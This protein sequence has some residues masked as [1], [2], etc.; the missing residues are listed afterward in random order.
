MKLNSIYRVFCK[1]IVRQL[2]PKVQEDARK[3]GLD[4]KVV[5]LDANRQETRVDCNIRN[6]EVI[7]V[8]PGFMPQVIN[9]GLPAVEGT[10]A[11]AIDIHKEGKLEIKVFKPQHSFLFFRNGMVSNLWNHLF[12]MFYLGAEKKDE[13]NGEKRWH[14]VYKPIFQ[15]PVPSYIMSDSQMREYLRDKLK[16]KVL[17]GHLKLLDELTL[18]PAK[19][20]KK[21][22][23]H[24]DKAPN[25]GV[26]ISGKS[27]DGL[28]GVVRAQ[29]EPGDELGEI[30]DN[31]SNRKDEKSGEGRKVEGK[32]SGKPKGKTK[33]N[34]QITADV[35][36]GVTDIAAE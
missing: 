21:P 5:V 17:D 6:G 33:S 8:V 11:V 32:P 15:C 22:A 25:N 19:T 2:L 31:K 30:P 24:Q 14:T 13:E 12:E 29:S 36:A 26:D 10:A 1:G 20:E 9:Y 34:Q 23:F 16:G 3:L 35:K 7:P 27:E 18:N 4:D 28:P